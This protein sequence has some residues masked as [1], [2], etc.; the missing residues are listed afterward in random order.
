MT[1]RKVLAIAGK[2]GKGGVF[3]AYDKSSKRSV[4]GIGGRGGSVFLSFSPDPLVKFSLHE[5]YIAGDGANGGN[6]GARGRSGIDIQ[7]VSPRDYIWTDHRNSLKISSSS[8]ESKSQI[9][10]ATGGLGGSGNATMGKDLYEEGEYGQ[11]NFYDVECRIV[12]DFVLF[13]LPNSGKSTLMKCLAGVQTKISSIPFSTTTPRYF[14][15][16]L[17]NSKLVGADT[18]GIIDI[19]SLDRTTENLLAH[20]KKVLVM[21]DLQRKQTLE[22]ANYLRSMIP[23]GPQIITVGSK[24]DSEPAMNNMKTGLCDIAISCKSGLGIQGLVQYLIGK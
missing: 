5:K 17:G 13:G 7:I 1:A 22:Y 16:L 10:L 4:G 9:A 18:P 20:A 11:C 24:C 3:F 23:D 2:G 19:N 21:V 8:Q 6:E 15:V 14:S 12:A